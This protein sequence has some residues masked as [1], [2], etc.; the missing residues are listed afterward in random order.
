M[1]C[2]VAKAESHHIAVFCKALLACGLNS[3]RVRY[4]ASGRY[5]D[6]FTVRVTQSQEVVA[7]ISTYREGC[8]RAVGRQMQ[9]GNYEKAKKIIASDAISI[10]NTLS[11]VTN[12]MLSRGVTP[13]LVWAF[14]HFDCKG[15]NQQACHTRLGP[16]IRKRMRELHKEGSKLQGLYSNVSFHERFHNDLTDFLHD[17]HVTAYAV[18]CIIFQVVYTVGCL[19]AIM[20]GFRHNDLSTNNVFV[21]A[22]DTDEATC[23]RY[24]LDGSVLYTAMPGI[25]VALADWDFAH[26]QNNVKYAGFEAPLRN[27][28]VVS[29][30]YSLKPKP[31]PT[32]DVHFFFTT[33]L[34]QLKSHPRA[35]ADI[36]TFLR[37]VSGR[38]SDRTDILL[39]RLQPS[40]LLKHAFFDELREKPLLPVRNSYGLSSELVPLSS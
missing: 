37:A 23:D 21:S 4:L 12:L 14:G 29:G 6:C 16:S 1:A 5:S 10:S 3:E 7:K 24:E 9:M 22:D 38:W 11:S 39:P 35:Y 26:C 27:E 25:T 17:N 32:Y 8:L 2:R 34:Q 28:R 19:Q 20:P 30:A 33:L 36:N 18:K 13:H 31:N 15:F 40:I